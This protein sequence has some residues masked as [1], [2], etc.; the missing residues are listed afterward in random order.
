MA[1]VEKKVNDLSTIIEGVS[2]SLEQIGEYVTTRKS[3]KAY[4]V[5]EKTFSSS[6]VNKESDLES[7]VNKY[8]DDGLSFTDAYAKAKKEQA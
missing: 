6:E 5:L 1:I 3:V 8:Q 2:K 7:V 4:Q